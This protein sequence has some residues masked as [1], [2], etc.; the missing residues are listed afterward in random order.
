M[1]KEN[2][3]DLITVKEMMLLNGNKEMTE[4]VNNFINNIIIYFREELKLEEVEKYIIKQREEILKFI[5]KHEDSSI[6]DN[7]FCFLEFKYGNVEKQKIV[8][9]MT[10]DEITVKDFCRAYGMVSARKYIAEHIKNI[11]GTTEDE[12]EFLDNGVADTLAYNVSILMNKMTVN[13]AIESVSGDEE[14]Y[15]KRNKY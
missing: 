14:N 13:D 2:K 11:F 12:K 7:F 3:E 4:I 5:L 15:Y 1:E 9:E 10:F 8:D 6:E